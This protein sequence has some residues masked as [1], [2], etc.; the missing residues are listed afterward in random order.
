MRRME[1]VDQPSEEKLT[2]SQISRRTLQKYLL[3]QIPGAVIVG[4]L[5]LALHAAEWLSTATSV[6]FFIGW[7]AKDALMYRF[8][9]TAYGPGPPHGTAALVGQRGVVVDDL[10]PEGSVRLGAERWSARPVDGISSL[11]SG[12]QVRVVSVSGYVVT[13]VDDRNA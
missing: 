2:E 8:V 5:L 10:T 9:R 13:V 12:T 6:A 11:S 3:L 7:C 4:L 1:T